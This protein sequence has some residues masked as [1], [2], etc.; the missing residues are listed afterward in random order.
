M[1][2][3]CSFLLLLTIFTP[4]KAQK[5]SDKEFEVSIETL[6][7]TTTVFFYRDEDL[8]RLEQ[9]KKAVSEAWNVTPLVFANYSDMEKYDNPGYSHFALKGMTTIRSNA[10]LSHRT[11][12]THKFLSLYLISSQR[13]KM[14]H[15]DLCRVELF[16][17]WKDD[18]KLFPDEKRYFNF[19][20]VQVGA[21][22]K[23]L[24]TDLQNSIIRDVFHQVKQPISQLL[25]KDTLYVPDNVLIDFGAMNGKESK[26]KENVFANYPFAF[27]ICS[28]QEL[29]NIFIK[30]GNGR[31]LFD[32]TK[33]STNKFVS[34][35]DVKEGKLIHRVYMPTS[36][37]LK[38]K[39]ID[40]LLEF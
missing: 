32:Y 16:S 34:I 6:K 8:G 33:S 40:R 30:N 9:Y 28:A 27:K 2:V 29:Y 12:N 1:K 11:E 14:K 17:R 24:N 20:P 26:Q 15:H 36:Y 23:V 35:I 18:D 7:S 21:F 5:Q 13:G 39:D 31:Y 25:R 3:I 22:L 19:S 37:N 38:V 4:G 10:T